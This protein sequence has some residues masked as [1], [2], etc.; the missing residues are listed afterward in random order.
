[1]LIAAI[2]MEKLFTFLAHVLFK[3]LWG[4]LSNRKTKFTSGIKTGPNGSRSTILNVQEKLD[5]RLMAAADIELNGLVKVYP[6]GEKA[7]NGLSLR[8][9]RGQVSILLGHNGCGKSTTFGMITGMHKATEGRVLIG[10]VDASSNRAEARKLIGYCPQYN[11]LY[12]KLTVIE[13]LR[14]VNALKGGSGA[15]FN[16][17]AQSLLEQIELT[18]KKNT[19]AKNLS[20]GMKR[21]LCVCMAMIGGSKV[22]LLDEPTAGMD[23]A[24][25]IDVQKMLA[26]VKSD[27]T[28]LLTTHYMDEAEKLG[29]WVFVMSHGKMAA[30]G[31]IHYLKQRYGGGMLLTL[32]FKTSSDPKKMYTAAL[33]VCKAIC[34]SATVVSWGRYSRKKL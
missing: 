21:K 18:D 26:L 16:A 25:R 22:I 30:S 27:R 19:L 11:P 13:H 9:V 4:I 31:S 20:G 14:L 7:V 5:G 32:V 33:Q 28:I 17:D 1:M 8:A 34:P 15:T 12:E 6:N 23:P 2:F 10:G 29:D 3:K 24:A